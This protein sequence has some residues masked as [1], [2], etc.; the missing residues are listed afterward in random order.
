MPQVPR[1]INRKVR[2][3]QKMFYKTSQI[4]DAT[5][6][7]FKEYPFPGN[8]DDCDGVRDLHVSNR[9]VVVHFLSKDCA[10]QTITAVS[11]KKAVLQELWCQRKSALNKWLIH[12]EGIYVFRLNPEAWTLE[13]IE[14]NTGECEAKKVCQ[15]L[16]DI[17]SIGEG[18]ILDRGEGP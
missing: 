17:Q 4:F 12:V 7:S 10:T 6:N 2:M 15:D 1:Q 11:F 8:G 14:L 5:N 13:K 16:A 3:H 9:V 18:V